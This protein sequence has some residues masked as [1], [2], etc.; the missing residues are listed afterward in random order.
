MP[1]ALDFVRDCGERWGVNIVWLEY[2][3]GLPARF[4]IVDHVTAS[5][6]GEP[7]ERLL[8][9]RGMLPNPVTRLSA[10]PCYRVNMPMDP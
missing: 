5:R 10:L 1:Q 8:G 2:N 4:A 7:F 9:N 6:N 3:P